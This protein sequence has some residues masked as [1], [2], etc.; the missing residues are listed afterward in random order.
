MNKRTTCF[1]DPRQISL[2]ILGESKPVNRLLFPLKPSENHTFSAD[3]KG[4][5]TTVN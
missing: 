1:K 3:F 2:Q 5:N 4:R